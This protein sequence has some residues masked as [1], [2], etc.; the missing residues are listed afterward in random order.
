LRK[1]N[2]LIVSKEEIHAL[3][4]QGKGKLLNERKIKLDEGWGKYSPFV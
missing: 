4:V 3:E 2:T 1:G